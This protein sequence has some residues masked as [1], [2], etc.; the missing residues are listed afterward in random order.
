MNSVTPIYQF[1]FFLPSSRIAIYLLSNDTKLTA[2]G[3]QYN[4]MVENNCEGVVHIGRWED[5][6]LLGQYWAACS[7]LA[8]CLGTL[9]C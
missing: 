9:T 2:I 5:A 6:M 4:W 7:L 8:H 1:R 3:G